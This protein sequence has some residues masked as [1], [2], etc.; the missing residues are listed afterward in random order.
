MKT[1]VI[2][3][4]TRG[5]GLGLAREFLRQGQQVTICGRNNSSLEKAVS[6]LGA[7]FDPNQILGYACDIS[8]PAEVQALWNA[9]TARFGKVDIWINNAGQ[10][11]DRQSFWEVPAAKVQEV[12]HSNLLGVMYGSQVAVRGMLKQGYGQIYNME[13]QGSSGRPSP[14]GLLYTTTKNGLTFF[15]KGLMQE[16]KKTPV[17]VN[18]L[19]PGMVI[20]DLL[21]NSLHTSQNPERTK[22]VFNIL[23]DKVETVTPFLAEKILANHKRGQKIAWLTPQKVIKRFIDARLGRNKR[24]LFA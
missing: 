17:Q 22:Q 3:G 19:S 4:S 24:D 8:Q 14:G 18:L 23:A 20:T 11:A 1:I 12:V 2:T 9:A 6:E 10:S 21:L 7:E 13:G 15:T 16:T 5:I